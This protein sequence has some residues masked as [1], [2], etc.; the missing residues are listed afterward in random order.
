MFNGGGGRRLPQP[1][2]WRPGKIYGRVPFLWGRDRIL[3]IK[4][5]NA[6]AL[7]RGII[8]LWVPSDGR[9]T[10]KSTGVFWWRRR[11]SDSCV[12]QIRLQPFVKV[13]RYSSWIS[14]LV[15]LWNL[16]FSPFQTIVE[17]KQQDYHL[18]LW[19]QHTTRSNIA[20]QSCLESAD[21]C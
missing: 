10:H 16:I 20:V 6:A 19:Q 9:Y 15:Y 7:V 2:A 18:R 17:L 8:A 21:L 1:A 13:C 12:Y 11:A 14:P 5:L 3:G 4:G